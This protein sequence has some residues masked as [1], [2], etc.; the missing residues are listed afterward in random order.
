V[1]GVLASLAVVVVRPG[2]VLVGEGVRPAQSL[3]WP[4]AADRAHEMHHAQMLAQ[5]GL[6]HAP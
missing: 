6:G 4:V 3:G 2:D 1:A 5:L